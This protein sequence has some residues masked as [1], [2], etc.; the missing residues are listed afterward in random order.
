MLILYLEHAYYNAL[1]LC[2]LH[3]CNDTYKNT[4]ANLIS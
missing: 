1:Q 3:L 2:V 4:N